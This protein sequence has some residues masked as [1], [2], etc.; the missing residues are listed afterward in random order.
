[1][2][3]KSLLLPTFPHHTHEVELLVGATLLLATV[4]GLVKPERVKTH[5]QAFA[6]SGQSI[7]LEDYDHFKY[8]YGQYKSRLGDTSDNP[9]HHRQCLAEDVS[10]M[11]FISLWLCCDN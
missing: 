6:L 3:S 8:L 9:S 4:V 10:K 5:S 1:M 2:T 11:F 7:N